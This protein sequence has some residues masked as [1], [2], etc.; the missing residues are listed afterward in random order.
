MI[1]YDPSEGRSVS[2]LPQ[3]I[4][5]AGHS[6]PGLEKVTG[7]DLL[8]TPV[9]DDSLAGQNI[10]QQPA[11]D[12]LFSFLESGMLI[13]RKT[14]ADMMSSI[15][16]LD[17]CQVRMQRV[18]DE[19]I[20]LGLTPPSIWLLLIG[21]YEPLMVD[22]RNTA[23]RYGLPYKCV[24]QIMTIREGNLGEQWPWAAFRGAQDRWMLRG[25]FVVCEPW[26]TTASDWLLRWNK[27]IKHLEAEKMVIRHQRLVENDNL[28]LNL[29]L[30]LPNCGPRIAQRLLDEVGS[31]TEVFLWVA[32][33]DRKKVEGVGEKRIAV[34]RKIL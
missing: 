17:E 16:H 15:P 3:V 18:Q 27:N 11:S 24:G 2:A 12:R 19:M 32:N 30:A 8:I 9:E 13:Q 28:S 1:F 26:N 29:L 22:N 33:E 34:W 10:T 23:K 21:L 25:G 5:D 20:A 7:A 6:L 31:P 14:G 4:K